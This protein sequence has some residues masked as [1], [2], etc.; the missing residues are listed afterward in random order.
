MQVFTNQ[1]PFHEARTDVAVLLRLNKGLRPSKPSP[2]QASELSA[3]IWEIMERC[4]NQSP[5][6]RPSVDQVAESL[7][8]V[9]PTS[10]GRRMKIQ[11]RERKQDAEVD[12]MT[13]RAAMRGQNMTFSDAE[14][15]LLRESA[16]VPSQSTPDSNIALPDADDPESIA[17]GLLDTAFVEAAAGGIDNSNILNESQAAL[18]TAHL[19]AASDGREESPAENKSLSTDLIRERDTSTLSSTSSEPEGSQGRNTEPVPVVISAGLR[20]AKTPDPEG[21]TQ[22][23]TSQPNISRL[24]SFSRLLRSLFYT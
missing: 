24:A 21:E 14:I 13:F 2:D 12:T 1:L 3:E 9:S 19:A 18:E 7:F 8:A 4:W 6:E 10:T 23:Q 11:T 20:R 22:A 16:E 5:D 17:L 15:N